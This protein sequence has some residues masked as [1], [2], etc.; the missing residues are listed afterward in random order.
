[1]AT[2]DANGMVFYGPTDP[3]EPLQGLFNG[4]SSAISAKFGAQTQIVRIAN[5]AG[6]AAAISDRSGRPISAADPLVT[7][8]ADAA[9]GT[10]MEYTTNGTSW[11]TYFA[12]TDT[13]WV[14]GVGGAGWGGNPQFRLYNGVVYGRGNWIRTGGNVAITFAGVSVGTIPAIIPN[15]SEEIMTPLST[16]VDVRLG[17]VISPG[18]SISLRNHYGSNPTYPTNQYASFNFSYLAS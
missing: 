6:R 5:I 13:G 17:W 1:M 11:S 9:A 14:A 3:V 18:G 10:Q 7:W 8:R 4:Q 12:G 16:G 15:P 2:T